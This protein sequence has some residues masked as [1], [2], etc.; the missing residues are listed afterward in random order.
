MAAPTSASSFP[1][2]CPPGAAGTLQARLQL[3]A[4]VRAGTTLRYTVTLTNPTKTAV[5]LHPCPGYTEGL[6]ASGL[7]VRRS[8]A[9]NCRPVHAIAAHGHVRYAMRLA[10]PRR[11]AQSIAKIGW[12]LDTPTGPFAGGVVRIT[13][14]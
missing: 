8:F 12:N 4:G 14:G 2:I 13:A 10:V 7:V 6:Y 5:V 3:P 9:L 1:P 11:A